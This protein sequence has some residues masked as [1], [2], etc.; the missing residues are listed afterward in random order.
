MIGAAGFR[1][2]RL[3]VLAADLVDF[4]DFVVRDAGLKAE[5][6]LSSRS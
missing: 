3:V 4:A 5:F 6:K 2:V 1:V